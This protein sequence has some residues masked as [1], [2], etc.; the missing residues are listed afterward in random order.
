[1]KMITTMLTMTTEDDD[2]ADDDDND[3][4]GDDDDAIM[5]MAPSLARTMAMM[6]TRSRASTMHAPVAHGA[7]LSCVARVRMSSASYTVLFM[8][9]YRALRLYSVL[10]S[11]IPFYTS[12]V[13]DVRTSLFFRF[14]RLNCE[15]IPF[16]D[17]VYTCVYTVFILF[18]VCMLYA[19]LFACRTL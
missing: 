16:Y 12:S 6:M 5:M 2:D 13:L 19:I 18:L 10:C 14:V 3:D 17:V 11:C 7:P 1:M 4:D 15:R 9:L 8:S